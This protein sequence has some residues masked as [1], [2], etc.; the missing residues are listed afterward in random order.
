MKSVQVI[1]NWL[2]DKLVKE[3]S[4]RHFTLFAILSFLYSTSLQRF[5]KNPE[6]RK[7]RNFGADEKDVNP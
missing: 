7:F 3:F 1:Y 6:I 4:S 5:L 2:D